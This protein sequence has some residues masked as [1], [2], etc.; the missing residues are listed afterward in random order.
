MA[1]KRLNPEAR[2]KI[3]CE[4]DDS[5]VPETEAE[6]TATAP[7]APTRYEQ[8][9]EEL[10]ES[11]LQFR[12][13]AAPSRFVLRC[14]TSSELGCLQEEY[15]GYDEERKSQV[16]KGSRSKYIRRVFELCVISI[17]DENGVEAKV[18]PDEIGYGVMAAIGSTVSMFTALGRNSKAS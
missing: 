4:F 2:F 9:L 13:G 1:V 7:G 5:L 17:I 15:F 12:D 14:L 3:I 10:D 8:Y 18:T 11:K 16:F 6:L